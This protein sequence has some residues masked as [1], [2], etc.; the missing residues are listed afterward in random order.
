MVDMDEDDGLAFGEDIIGG[1]PYGVL[2]A[3]VP[4]DGDGDQSIPHRGFLLHMTL[5]YPHS[6]SLWQLRIKQS[7]LGWVTTKSWTVFDDQSS[8]LKRCTRYFLFFRCQRLF[9]SF[10]VCSL[11]LC[12][13][14]R[15]SF[16]KNC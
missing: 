2:A 5:S 4:V 16:L 3:F 6:L 9:L 12:T 8:P 1:P 11:V 15:A 14:D 7:D 13:K 10:T